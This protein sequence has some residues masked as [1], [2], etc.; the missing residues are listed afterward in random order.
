MEE[1]L[2]V[3]GEFIQNI[4]TQIN[5]I[6]HICQDKEINK[7]LNK[8]LKYINDNTSTAS[9]D[10]E[11]LASLIKIRMKETRN[12]DPD[13]ETRYYMLHQDLINGRITIGQAEELYRRYVVL[14]KYEEK[15]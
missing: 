1:D 4:E 15:R 12:T 9:Y 6:V 5:D 2:L 3:T 8:L 14:Q 13:L 7:K 10:A 11:K